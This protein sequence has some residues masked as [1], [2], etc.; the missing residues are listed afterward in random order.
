M[1]DRLPPALAGT[2]LRVLATTDLGAAFVPVPTSFGPA[3]TCAGVAG[4]LAA[5]QARQPT[6]WLDAGD[7]TVGPVPLLLGRRPWPE[8]AGLPLSAA[9]AGNHEFDDGVPA[10]RAAARLLPYPLLCADVDAGL[11]PATL[12]ETRAGPVGVLGLTHPAADGSPRR[13]RPLRAGPRG[14]PGWRRAPRRGRTGWT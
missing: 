5:E 9:A 1:D 2:A 10:L 11:P 7:L 14:W 6:I 12:L 4:M 8:M 13:R 3:G